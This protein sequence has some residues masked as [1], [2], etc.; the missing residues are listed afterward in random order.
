[1]KSVIAALLILTLATPAFAQ[2]AKCVGGYRLANADFY[3]KTN[4]LKTLETVS[5][6]AKW[7]GVPGGVACMILATRSWWGRAACA[8]VGLSVSAAGYYYGNMYAASI[9]REANLKQTED[10]FLIYQIYRAHRMDEAAT[11][12][13]VAI[14]MRALGVNLDDGNDHSE[15]AK[16]VAGILAELM[17]NG[18]LCEGGSTPKADYWSLVDLI[19]ARL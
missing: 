15:E 7:A 4:N 5:G 19:K 12:A 8:V 3:T 17:E 18:D 6:A 14:M 16:K 10:S 11:S 2:E 1:M 13:D 9:V